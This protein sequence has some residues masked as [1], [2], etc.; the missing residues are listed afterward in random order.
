MT[1]S[2][3]KSNPKGALIKLGL[4]P[5]TIDVNR[6]CFLVVVGLNHLF[7]KEDVFISGPLEIDTAFEFHV[8]FHY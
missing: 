7:C 3:V 4:Y 2:K 1:G 6:F 8:F 5:S